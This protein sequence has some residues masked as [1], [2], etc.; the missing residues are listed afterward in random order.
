MRVTTRTVTDAAGQTIESGTTTYD[1]DNHVLSV[2]AQKL[3]ASGSPVMV[4]DSYTYATG[5]LV[6]ESHVTITRLDGISRFLTT[7]YAWN[8]DHCP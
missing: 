8:Y 1:I 5:R 3:D 6:S 2:L 7:R 4:T